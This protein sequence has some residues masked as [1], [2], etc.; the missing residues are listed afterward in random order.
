[1]R[2]VP[3]PSLEP[4]PKA[5]IVSG[6][7]GIGGGSF[8]SHPRIESDLSSVE[9]ASHYADQ[10]RDQGWTLE[11]QEEGKDA[12]NQTWRFKDESGQTWCGFL[13]VMPFPG[14]SEQKILFHIAK[15]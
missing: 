7:R 1:M 2:D 8:S 3:R 9:L 4:P 13:V 15:Q 14:T 11:S 10:L 6:G 5:P 12:V